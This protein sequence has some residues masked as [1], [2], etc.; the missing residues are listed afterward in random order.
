MPVFPPRAGLVAEIY[1]MR[2]RTRCFVPASEVIT[3][4]AEKGI[5]QHLSRGCLAVR[6]SPAS[7]SVKG[8]KTLTVRDAQKQPTGRHVAA[9]THRHDSE[10]K[11]AK[12]PPS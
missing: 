5:P 1:T 2:I 9:S 10:R 12:Q 3:T 4:T 7:R 11:P 8:A 6:P